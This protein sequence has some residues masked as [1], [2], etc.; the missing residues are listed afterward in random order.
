[1]TTTEHQAAMRAAHE[2]QLRAAQRRIDRAREREAE[3]VAAAQGTAKAALE[4][5]MSE[6]AVAEHLGI[7]RNTLRDW[8]GKPRTR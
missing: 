8:L 1:M 6:R 3:A 2:R 7:A 4:A 5:G